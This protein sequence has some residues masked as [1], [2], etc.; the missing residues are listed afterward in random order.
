M[1][2]TK[3]RPSEE[4]LRIKQQVELMRITQQRLQEEREKKK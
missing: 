3:P 2:E 4:F 1:P